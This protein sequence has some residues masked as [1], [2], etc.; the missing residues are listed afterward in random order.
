MADLDLKQYIDQFLDYLEIERNCSPLT[1][2]NYRHY[3]KRF[4]KFLKKEDSGQLPTLAN[5]NMEN[6][7]KFRIY[8][9][10]LETKE[11]AFLKKVTQGYH[12]IALRAFLKWL[13]KNDKKV[14]APEKI[15]LPKKEDR[16]LKFLT[17]EQVERLLNQPLISSKNGLRDK[18]ILEMLFSTGLR[19]SELSALNRDQ[20]NLKTRELSIIG[21]G[22]KA[23]V[24]FISK[25][26]V[27]WLGR[28]LVSRDDH[29]SPLF[30]RYSGKMGV[31]VADEAM[32]LSVRSIQRVIEKYRKKAQIPIRVTPHVLR[33]SFATDLLFH[34]AD[35]RS[36]QE[37]LGHKNIAT[38]Q[39][40]THVTDKRLRETHEKFHSG[41]E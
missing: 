9:A 31:D 38:T 23:R 34:G 11:G 5:L 40:Y 41:N 35:L 10:R 6:V 30:I 19:V 37:L 14:V 3:L 20:I 24:V 33:H 27:S 16:Q 2:R 36:V 21:K 8:L 39:I 4:Y 28:Y 12:V 25:R 18:S 29:Y 13:I 1:T 32:R 22:R 17:A 7:R 15:E 26:A